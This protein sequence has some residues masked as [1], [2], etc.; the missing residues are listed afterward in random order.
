MENVKKRRGFTMKMENV[1]ARLHHR[2]GECEE[3]ERLHHE[4]VKKRRGF[5]MKM[6]N[7]K[8]RQGFTQKWRM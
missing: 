5:T 8:K 6:E 2:N 1:K 4:N 3:K 7:G